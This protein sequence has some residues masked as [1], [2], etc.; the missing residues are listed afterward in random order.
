MVPVT[1]DG[2]GKTV[3]MSYDQVPE[4]I[5]ENPENNSSNHRRA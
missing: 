4:D 3:T 2:K 1:D 5:L